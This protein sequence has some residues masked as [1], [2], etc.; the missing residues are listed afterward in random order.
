MQIMKK[1][2]NIERHAS[3]RGL[4]AALDTLKTLDAEVVSRCP[5]EDCA[6]CAPAV[7]A[8]A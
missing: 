2:E 5:V 6:V 8:A 3:A 7:P 4:A 1:N